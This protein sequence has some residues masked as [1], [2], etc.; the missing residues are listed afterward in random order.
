MDDPLDRNDPYAVDAETFFE[1]S[2]IQLCASCG[3]PIAAP[4]WSRESFTPHEVHPV[5]FAYI[6]AYGPLP[7]GRMARR[8]CGDAL[9]SN[10][11]HLALM[12]PARPA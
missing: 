5:C 12:A 11:R 6:R 9:C 8:T 3:E 4:R 2:G 1:L 7:P 10:A